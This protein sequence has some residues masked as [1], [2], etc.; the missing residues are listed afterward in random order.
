M[1]A[2][3]YLLMLAPVIAIPVIWW[4]Y[5][6]KHAQREGASSLRWGELVDAAK[7]SD[8]VNPPASGATFMPVVEAGR[9]LAPAATSLPP[10]IRRE[11]TL[12]AAETVVYY[13][14]KNALADHE[15]MPHV[16]LASV[17]AVPESIAGQAREQRTRGLAQQAVDFL[18]CNKAMQ[19]VAA[20][21]LLA[22]A[23]P[24]A[25]TAAPDFKTQCFAQTE[26]RYLRWARTAIPKRETVRA[27]VLGA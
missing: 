12:D 24:S 7:K 21:D 27:L 25:L 1:I 8:P 6:R 4:N 2:I 13:L 17:L 18:V 22:Q 26:I 5:R 16:T 15:V 14:L 20:I 3:W 23:A 10:Y 19:P 9:G 11:R